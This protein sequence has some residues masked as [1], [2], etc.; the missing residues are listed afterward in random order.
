MSMYRMKESTLNKSVVKWLNSL[1]GCHAYKR[2]GG[3]HNRGMP[4]ITGCLHGIRLE[5]EGK[6]G[7]NK[8]TKTQAYHLAK[9]KAAGAISNFFT[10]LDQAKEIVT[11]QIYVKTGIKIEA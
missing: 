2:Y 7:S 10:S 6:I 9:W 11:T 3:P 8:P 1:N 4:D 5:L